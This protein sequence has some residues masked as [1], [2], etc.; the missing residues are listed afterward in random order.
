MA[1]QSAGFL[2]NLVSSVS[3]IGQENNQFRQAATQQNS[4]ISK[5]IRDISK[6]FSGQSKTQGD[7]NESL[8]NLSQS[9]ISTS[10]KVDQ[11]NSLL[12]QSISIQTQMYNE[13]KTMSRLLT[14]S[15]N[16]AE[17]GEQGAGGGGIFSALRNNLG[18]IVGGSI[19]AGLIA[20]GELL[21]SGFGGIT[22]M[23]QNSNFQQTN[24]QGTTAQVLDTIKSV[25]SGGDYGTP[26]KAGASSASG[27][28]QFIDSTW[29]N[30]TKKYGIGEEYP[31]AMYAPPQIQDAVAAK[32]VE[33]ILSQ[34][35][36]DVSKVPLVWYTGNP[37]GKMSGEALSSNKGQQAQT[38]QKKWINTF[39]KIS[40]QEKDDAS[41]PQGTIVEKEGATT[42][43]YGG[44]IQEKQDELAGV[45]KLPLSGRLK[46]VLDQ[47][48]AAAGVEAVVYSG[49]QAPKGSGGARTGSTRHDNGNAADLYLMKDGRKLADTN[50]EDRAIMA[51]FVSSAVQ[52]GATGVGAGHGYMG[53]SNIHVG[54]GKQATW[55]GADWIKQ[56]ASG[57][58]N[59]KDLSSEGG[60]YAG[61]GGQQSFTGIPSVDNM[62]GGLVQSFG[63]I[64]LG[65]GI[66]GGVT[67]ALG[68]LAGGFPMMAQLLSGFMGPAG[69]TG[70]LISQGSNET[71]NDMV[72]S[73][74]NYMNKSSAMEM[75]AIE[76][77]LM[78]LTPQMTQQSA[79]AQVTGAAAP[80]AT[81]ANRDGD[82]YGPGRYTSS[83][84]WYSQLAGRIHHDNVMKFKGGVL[85]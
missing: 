18:A 65:G 25:E 36:N 22:N 41:A 32:Y 13:L 45:R 26:N 60:S 6:V 8:S 76:R 63:G 21:E 27:A 57:I 79:P 3:K 30:L 74:S 56:A 81:V 82:P 68:T 37:Q 85:A 46:S 44:G 72:E 31:R 70:N 4:S 62:L 14:R 54:F 19:G 15:I 40:G 34:N 73:D 80:K 55:G 39:S 20:G 33:E 67:Q 50:P 61:G 75:A 47:A 17:S 83:S 28:Y 1:E 77:D 5:F 48:A 66:G 43:S 38:Y 29:E 9:T 42:N 71:D 52:A 58:Y 78:A 16:V 12:S 51:K 2:K 53:P 64:G 7:I 23:S 49:G 10:Q 35:N 59:N 11:T 84:S 69:S 24:I